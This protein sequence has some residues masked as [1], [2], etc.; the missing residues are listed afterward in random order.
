MIIIVIACKNYERLKRFKK[1]LCHVKDVGILHH[2][3]GMKVVQDE[4]SKDVWIG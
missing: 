2:F 3:L 1:E 4:S